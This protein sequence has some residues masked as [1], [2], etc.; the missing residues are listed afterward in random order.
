MRR[1]PTSFATAKPTLQASEISCK[2]GGG[3][4]DVGLYLGGGM[5]EE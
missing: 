5:D 1:L 3:L 4:D 2:Q